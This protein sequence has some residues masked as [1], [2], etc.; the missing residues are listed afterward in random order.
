M[1]RANTAMSWYYLLEM[2]YK[3]CVFRMYNTTLNC[4]QV[5]VQFNTTQQRV[6]TKCAASRINTGLQC[7]IRNGTAANCYDDDANVKLCL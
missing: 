2:A 5:N 7:L 4:C 3:V 1:R 6:R